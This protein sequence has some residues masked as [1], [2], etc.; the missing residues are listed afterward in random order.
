MKV[1]TSKYLLDTSREYAVYTA[2]TRGIASV[3]DGLK[4]SQRIALWLLRNKA[5]KVKTVGLAG[6]MAAEKLYVH[7]DASAHG[8]INLLAAP[9]KNNV[10]LIQGEGEFGS[11]I[12]PDGIG[13]PRYTEVKRSK[14]A[15][16]FLYADLPNVPLTR[17]YDGSNWQPKYF[18]PLIPTVLLNG[19]TGVAVGFSTAILPHSL[20]D[21]VKATL[22]VLEGREP[23]F[24]MPTW[25]MYDVTVKNIAPNKYEI[26]GKCEIID[27]STIRVTELPPGLS[28]DDFRERLIQMEADG[29]IQDFDDHSAER[30]NVDVRLKRGTLKGTPATTETIDGKK[31]KI[32]AKKA[33]TVKDCMDFLKLREKITERIVVIDWDNESI[34][35]YDDP[36]DLI[37]DFVQFRLGVYVERYKRLQSEAEYEIVYWKTLKALFEGGFTKKLGTFAGKAEVL[38]EIGTVAKKA[39]LTPDEDQIERAAGLPTYRWTVEFKKTVEERIKELEG[40]IKEYKA[41]LKDPKRIRSIYASELEEL[42]K[43]K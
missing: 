31:F 42:K 11:R 24:L 39:K 2:D 40:Q 17:N 20:K 22:D 6:Q 14:A 13:A 36:L 12:K 15:E 5:E 19:V 35:T 37:R 41:N 1:T 25:D 26:E 16:A 28:L 29:K 18:L 23:K 8:A 43:L 10:P 33:W 7:G 21:I 30:I 32:P 27:T 4:T 9:F 3:V 34:K 38:A